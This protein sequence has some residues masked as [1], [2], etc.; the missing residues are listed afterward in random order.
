MLWAGLASYRFGIEFKN[1]VR[2]GNAES[3]VGSRW[4]LRGFERHEK[5]VRQ[6]ESE[7]FRERLG[8]GHG[9]LPWPGLQALQVSKTW[10]ELLQNMHHPASYEGDYSWI[11]SKLD[12]VMQNSSR[13]EREFLSGLAPFFIVIGHDPIGA[14]IVMNELLRRDPSYWKAWFWY[15]YHSLE[16]L[17]DRALAA[18]AFAHAAKLPGGPAFTAALSLRLSRGAKFFE[19]RERDEILRRNFSPEFIEKIKRA[20]PEYFE[21]SPRL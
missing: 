3:F 17:H 7:A 5:I 16:N 4:D 10:L 12:F 13:E 19:S 9:A 11:F 15:G 8:S 18:D 1:A 6:R 2:G 14:T 21:P 20:R